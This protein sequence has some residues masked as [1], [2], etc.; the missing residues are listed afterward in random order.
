MTTIP[1]DPTTL[2][3]GIAENARRNGKMARLPRATRDMINRMLDDGLP[4]HVILDELGD[5]AQGINFQ[6]LTNWKKGG[7]QDW[8]KNQERAERLRLEMET[9]IDLLKE[10]PDIDSKLVLKACSMLGAI[11]LFTALKEHGADAIRN[12]LRDKPEKYIGIFNLIC[13][14]ANTGLRYHEFNRSADALKEL[15]AAS[16]KLDQGKSR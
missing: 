3:P 16:I 14:V 12:M 7:Y 1:I 6:N 10:N 2:T 5:A 11:Q 4:Y 9:A 8:V 13:R 15:I